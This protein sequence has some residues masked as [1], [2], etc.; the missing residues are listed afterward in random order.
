LK[1]IL[2]ELIPVEPELDRILEKLKAAYHIVGDSTMINRI[3]RESFAGVADGTAHTI[4]ENHGFLVT[5]K[6]DDFE[7]ESMWIEVFKK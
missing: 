5:G 4:F 2:L 7:P 3:K 6:I 1:S